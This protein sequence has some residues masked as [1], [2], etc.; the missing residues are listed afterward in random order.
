MAV[1]AV[2]VA[3]V[4][5]ASWVATQRTP[6]VVPPPIAERP[7]PAPIRPGTPPPIRPAPPP[8]PPTPAQR[9][10]RTKIVGVQPAPV[11]TDQAI[12]ERPAAATAPQRDDWPPPPFVDLRLAS[13]KS[14]DTTVRSVQ[15][16]VSGDPPWAPGEIA[17]LEVVASREAEITVCVEGPERGV[18]WRGAVPAGRTVLSR[19]GRAVRFSFAA[20]GRYGFAVGSGGEGRCDTLIHRV[21]LEVQ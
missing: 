18:V 19:D 13:S 3:A 15:L 20:P 1:A 17:S 8:R 4:G 12:D 5:I 14:A 9:A 6:E 11:P 2:A 7:Q 16:V 10:P 21:A